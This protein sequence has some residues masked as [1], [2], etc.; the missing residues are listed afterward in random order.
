VVDPD[1]DRQAGVGPA[2]LGPAAGKARE[3]GDVER[4]HDPAVTGG[5]FK[6]RLIGH[7]IEIPFLVSSAHV[8]AAFA[9]RGGDTT[10]GDMGVEK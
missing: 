4:H 7:A 1:N 9:K 2:F 8:V 10:P 6:E 3:V 5:K